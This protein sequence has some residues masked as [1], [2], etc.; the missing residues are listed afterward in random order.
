MVEPVLVSAG[1]PF[2]FCEAEVHHFHQAVVGYHNI[3][4]FDVPMHNAFFMSGLQ[5]FGDLGG[6]IHCLR[7]GDRT[8][9]P[10]DFP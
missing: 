1:W 2:I 5:T 6:V 7:R 3:G 8:G 9:R 4:R 10:Y